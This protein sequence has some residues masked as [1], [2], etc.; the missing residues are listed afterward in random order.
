MKL[1]QLFA[2]NEPPK[3]L[4]GDNDWKIEYEIIVEPRHTTPESSARTWPRTSSWLRRPIVPTLP[5]LGGKLTRRWRMGLAD[6]DA[7]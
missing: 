7:C 5:A 3:T 1:D 2:D 4:W 6:D